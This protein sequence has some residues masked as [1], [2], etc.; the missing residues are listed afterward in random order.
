MCVCCVD[1]YVCVLCVRNT[2]IT[3]TH[4]MPHN[5]HNCVCHVCVSHTHVCV[6]MCV[7][8]VC[9]V[10]EYVCVLC[11]M[12]ERHTHSTHIRITCVCV[13]GMRVVWMNICVRYMCE[14]YVIQTTHNSN[15]QTY[16]YSRPNTV[17]HTQ[18]ALHIYSGPHT[19]R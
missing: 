9:C 11:A 15:I 2:H 3:H 10:N 12:S 18:F 8:S 13:C 14:I 19:L 5:T 1:E 4:I 6:N 16:T 7:C 17:D